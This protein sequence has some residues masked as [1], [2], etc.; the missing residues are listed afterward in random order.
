MRIRKLPRYISF[1]LAIVLSIAMALPSTTALADTYGAKSTG[2]N[3]AIE[4]EG[5][6]RNW[7]GVSNVSQFLD[8]DGN[9]CFA[10][11]KSKS[12]VI[13]KTKDGKPLKKTI[14][15]KMEYPLFG[16]VTC[17]KEGNY[18]LISGKSNTSKDYEKK[19]VFV[20]KYDKNGKLIKTVGDNGSSSIWAPS[21]FYTSYPFYGGNC[22]I[23]ING[24]Y[25]VVHYA[26][27]M[28]NGHQSNSVLAINVNTMSKVNIDNIY[29]SHSFA[30]RAIPYQD[31]FVFVS[32]GDGYNR[33]FTITTIADMSSRSNLTGDIFHFWVKKGT[34]DK[35]DMST[36]NNNFAH[37]GGL[38]AVSDSLVAFVG[39][40]A[41]SLTSKAASENEQLFIQIFDP[42]KELDSGYAY[43]TSGTRSGYSGANGDQ[44]VTNYGVK[45]LTSYSNKY[46]IS[47]PQ[48]VSDGNGN[49]VILYELYASD[50][51]KGVYYM[52]V[53]QKG[54][55]T[56]KKTKY[57]ATAMLNPCEMPICSNKTIYW[58]ANKDKASKD[59][60]YIY[61]LKIN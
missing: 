50:A 26:R 48:V 45:W 12:A 58:T 53:D 28:H 61:S 47:H 24:N 8:K 31:G 1:V 7:E 13:V 18:Y 37:M 10:Y 38:A 19:A 36:L 44:A 16:G 14:S 49:I 3:Y 57:S 35:W 41:K 20:S 55:I 2:I 60:M 27:M 9:Y 46:S 17:D 59:T 54:K 56:T 39:S 5:E 32:E 22:D 43:V 23:A 42:L 21:E 15:L 30:Q 29:S 51:Y 52:V 6:Y 25:L 40:S 33:A 11:H 4:A 34:L